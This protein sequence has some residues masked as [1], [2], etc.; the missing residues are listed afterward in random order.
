MKAHPIE[1][2]Q[3][4][5]KAVEQKTQTI[6]QIARLFNVSQ[7]YVYK[8]LKLERSG[9]SLSPKEH[10]GGAV[11]KLKAKHR[12]TLASLIAASPDATLE[13]LQRLLRQRTRVDASISTI[14]RAVDALGITVKKKRGVP[15]RPTPK[16]EQPSA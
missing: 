8:L 7:R 5:V 15:A 14:W 3:R 4:I 2:R 12:E 11:L 6:E 10:G 16:S 13:E 1:L 9:E